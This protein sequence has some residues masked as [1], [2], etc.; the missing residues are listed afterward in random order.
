MRVIKASEGTSQER[1]GQ[2]IFEGQ[3]WG[4]GLVEG[5]GHL[6]ASI[7]QFAVGGRTRMHTHTSDQLLYVVAGIGKV[8]TAE[9]EQLISTGDVALIPAG[10]AHWHGAGDSGSP[11]S[12]LT[13]MRADSETEVLG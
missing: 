13:V 5:E 12:H 11:M 2:P 8:G 10:E 6:T 9:G 7:V 1:T 4:R 3:V